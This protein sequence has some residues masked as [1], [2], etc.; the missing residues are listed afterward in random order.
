MGRLAVNGR[1]E[2]SVGFG[3]DEV[4][5]GDSTVEAEGRT[6]SCGLG[7]LEVVELELKVL[8]VFAGTE[9]AGVVMGE[10]TPL[11]GS[12]GISC[13]PPSCMSCR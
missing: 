9:E 4:I 7:V 10:D 11:S 2:L 8:D 13:V 3:I 6:I 5:A 1:L 12:G